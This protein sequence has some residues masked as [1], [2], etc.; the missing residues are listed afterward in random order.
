MEKQEGRLNGILITRALAITHLL[1]V[2][3]VLLFS[4]G[5]VKEWQLFKK[6]LNVFSSATGMVIVAQNLCSLSMVW[7][8]IL[9]LKL[10]IYLFLKLVT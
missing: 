9:Y 3:D 4:K 10:K 5:I 2:D 6:I 8:L 7:I 1:F